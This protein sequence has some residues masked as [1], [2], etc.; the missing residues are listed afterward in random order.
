MLFSSFV[1]SGTIDQQRESRVTGTGGQINLEL[2]S[3]AWAVTKNCN[4]PPVEFNER[5]YECEADPEAD[6]P[7]PRYVSALKE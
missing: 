5:L 1:F 3:A 4:S 7:L 2:G 6:R